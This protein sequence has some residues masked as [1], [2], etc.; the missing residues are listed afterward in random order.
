MNYETRLQERVDVERIGRVRIGD[1]AWA[2]HSSVILGNVDVGAG[3]VI[4]ARAVVT[5]DVPPFCVVAGN[6][7]RLVK[8]LPF[9]E[10]MR[11][12]LGEE[13]YRRYE[14]AWVLK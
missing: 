11:E 8:K 6:P 9:P 2:G 3:A 5:R 10:E 14:E 13:E 7:A 1:Y 12:K 4:A